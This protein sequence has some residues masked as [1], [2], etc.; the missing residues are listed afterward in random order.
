MLGTLALLVF[1]AGAGTYAYVRTHDGPIGATPGG[2]FR[3]GELTATPSNWN[4]VQ[5]EELMEFQTMSPSTTRE[6]WL[7]VYQGRLFAICA[8]MNEDRGAAK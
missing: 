4:F 7:G 6:V 1:L 8:G 2:P 3:S 5:D